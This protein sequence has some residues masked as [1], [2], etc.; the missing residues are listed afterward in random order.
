M[1]TRPGLTST[2][3]A[4][5]LRRDGP[6]ELPRPPRPHAWRM[7]LA[8]LTH[9][10]AAMLWIASALA[11]AAGMPQLS[12]AIV[13]VVVVNGIFAFLQEWRADRAAGRLRELVP[14]RAHVRRD[15]VA[16]FVPVADVVVGDVVLLQSGERV[17]ADLVLHD[18]HSLGLDESMLT[19]ES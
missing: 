3:A 12:V 10:F 8:Q 11:L 6:N 13:V 5:R 17:C 15:G 18:V 2:D 4:G 1:T 16:R 7:L 14:S 9:L 19:G